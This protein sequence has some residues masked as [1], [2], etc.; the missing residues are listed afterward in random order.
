MTLACFPHPVAR[1]P[2]LVRLGL[3][4]ISRRTCPVSLLSLGEG[5]WIRYVARD[6]SPSWTGTRQPSLKGMQRVAAGERLF[7]SLMNY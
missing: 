7:L 3:V 2:T 5:V 4:P 1:L 6:N